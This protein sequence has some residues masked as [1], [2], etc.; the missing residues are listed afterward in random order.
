M[1]PGLLLYTPTTH[2]EWEPMAIY[3]VEAVGEGSWIVAIPTDASASDAV[4]VPTLQG[5]LE[6]VEFVRLQIPPAL[7]ETPPRG[8]TRFEFESR[9]GDGL[10]LPQVVRRV[11]RDLA[12]P[13][14]QPVSD[15]TLAALQERIRTLESQ[16]QSS[17]REDAP[18]VRRLFGP[19]SAPQGDVE[20]ARL[21]AGAAPPTASV[22]RPR[23][24]QVPDPAPSS[25]PANS[26]V[27][28][29][30]S[31]LEA[32]V[33]TRQRDPEERE[34]GDA[35]AGVASGSGRGIA[36]LRSLADRNVRTPG[37]R[38]EHVSLVALD[39]GQETVAAYMENCTQMRRD[40]L[41]A[42]LTALFCR[43]AEAAEAGDCE[44]VLGRCAS[45][46]I[47]CDQ[48]SIDGNIQLAWQMTLE[49]EPAV[50]RRH[51]DTP[52]Q[53]AFP[54]NR[55]APFPQQQFSQLAEPQVTEAALAATKNW[56]DFREAAEK[57]QE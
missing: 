7:A 36:R 49:P 19:R 38:W 13:P 24:V 5:H 47:F 51:P 12:P 3:L 33:A 32:L 9:E 4:L 56:K 40:R 10:S 25:A 34:E 22:R 17:T 29:I 57:L 39:A 35:G 54:K 27:G 45:G 8:A 1:S 23:V 15:A 28:R 48:W 30:V 44:R 43:I 14:A 20:R 11:P 21:L 6:A 55:R 31:A 37:R 41:T 26:E 42:Y 50:L 52:L 16:S 18:Q 53:K 2:D 46:L